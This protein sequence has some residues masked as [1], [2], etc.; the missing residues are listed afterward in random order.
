MSKCMLNCIKNYETYVKEK[1]ET[2]DGIIATKEFF[3]SY[4]LDVISSCC[5][6]MDINSINGPNNEFLKNL[7]ILFSGLSRNPKLI[8]ICKNRP[9]KSI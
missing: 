2:S 7:Q 1:V 5:F 4:T 6:G 8:L 9:I 3:G